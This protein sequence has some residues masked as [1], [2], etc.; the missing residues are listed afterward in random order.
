MAW[1][2]VPGSDPALPGDY[3]LLRCAVCRSAVTVASA[4]AAAHEEGAYGAG[5]PRGA[6]LAAPL[7]RAFDRRRLAVL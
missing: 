2:T 4:P 7:L 5:A 6:G 3:E 1:R